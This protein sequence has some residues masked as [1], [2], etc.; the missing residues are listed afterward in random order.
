[1]AFVLSEQ[2]ALLACAAVIESAR[3]KRVEPLDP[4]KRPYNILV[5]Q[6]FLAVLAHRRTTAARLEREIGTLAAFRDLPRDTPAVLV[7][8]LEEGV[9]SSGD[10][11]FLMAG[12]RMEARMGG[13]RGRTFYSVIQGGGEVRAVTPD[14]EQIGRLGREACCRQGPGGFPRWVE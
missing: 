13:P 9:S 6:V 10:G 5:Q 11:E 14:G 3:K 7:T 2:G 1:M 8:F 12:P 4:K